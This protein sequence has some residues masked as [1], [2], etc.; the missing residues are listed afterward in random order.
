MVEDIFENFNSNRLRDI[1]TAF[2]L[3]RDELSASVAISEKKLT[4]IEQGAIQPSN[5]DI[6]QLCFKFG[7]TP[8]FFCLGNI[9]KVVRSSNLSPD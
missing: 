8:K 4:M 6:E 3:D 2:C 9:P 1:R 7:V 5:H